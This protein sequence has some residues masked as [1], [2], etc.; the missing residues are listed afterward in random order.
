MCNFCGSE[1]LCSALYCDNLGLIQKI[2]SRL[3]FRDWYPNETI[4]S[5]W[6][7]L[8]SIV[9][10]IRLFPKRP[11]IEH[12]RGHQDN[13]T[14]YDRLSLEAQLNVDADAAANQYQTLHGQNRFKVPIITGNRA[15]LTLQ[16]RTVTHH[17]V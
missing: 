2:N 7:V 16:D 11:Q 9:S 4:S 17:Y 15:Q 12:V 6:D 5:D 1:P 10:T 8:Q 14:S 3:R 13:D